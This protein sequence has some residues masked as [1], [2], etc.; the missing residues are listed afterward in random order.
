MS[1]KEDIEIIKN[2]TEIQSCSGN[3]S[4]IRE[5]IIG[6]VEPYCTK[7]ETDILGNLFCTIEGTEKQDRR[8]KVLLDAHMD[9]IGFMVRYIDKNGFIR[10]SQ[11]GGQNPRI[12][13]GQ[14]VTIH[15]SSGEDLL[16]VIGET[17]IHLLQP[18]ERKKAAKLEDLFIDIGMENIKQVK[19]LVSIGDYITLNEECVVFKGGKRICSKAF[20]DRAGCFVLVK[21][22]KALSEQKERLNKDFV[23]Q[24]ASQE[25]I[26]VRGATVGAFKIFP[27]FAIVVE[28]THAIDFPGISKDKHYECNLGSGVSINVGPN[29]H[30]KLSKMLIEI[31]KKE[32]IPFVLEAEPRPTP[33]DARAIQMTKT[34][35][36][37]ALVATPVRYMHTNIEVIDYKDLIHTVNLLKAF[38]FQ[39]VD[40]SF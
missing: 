23:F 11:V 36:P 6:L 24:F 12:L 9:E 4:K 18:E 25:E 22:I 34:G 14:K 10:F 1:L 2:L 19:K 28:V 13:P 38:L 21:L 20:D 17:P 33:T 29:L 16:G 8:I 15:S 7:T 39:D 40:F 37:C 35:I 3:E 5:Y 30:P 32:R 26:G 27:D 31:A